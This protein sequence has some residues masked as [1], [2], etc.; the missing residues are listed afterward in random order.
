MSVPNQF[1]MGNVEEIHSFIREFS[2]ATLV[3]SHLR[4]SHLPMLLVAEEGELGTLYC[5]FAKANSHHR[6]IE[7]QAV[8]CVFNGPH[9]Y[10]SPYW[11]AGKP[12]VPTWN[13][14][15]VHAT[16]QAEVLN[17]QQTSDLMQQTLRVYQPELL[18]DK[19]MMPDKY[20]AGLS[21]AVVGCKIRLFHLE[22]INKLG[23]HRNAADQQSIY[24]ALANH[25][26]AN[27]NQLADYMRQKGLA[28]N[29]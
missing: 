6:N 22:V 7:G 26:S 24:Q 19:Q 5:H 17:Q 29:A 18:N 9:S 23:Q 2:F 4:V 12:N 3:S 20:L 15:A 11:Y 21:K 1:A 14:A 8:L 16:G 13:Y 10:I 27:A 28:K 25:S